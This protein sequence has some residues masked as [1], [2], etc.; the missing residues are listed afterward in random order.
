MCGQHHTNP[1]C[2]LKLLT[3]PGGP[4]LLNTGGCAVPASL[5]PSQPCAAADQ[6]VCD[7]HLQAIN[8][9]HD[10]TAL[11]SGVLLAVSPQHVCSQLRDLCLAAWRG[12]AAR[13]QTG[14]QKSGN[15]YNWNVESQ[16]Q[17]TTY[18]C[19]CDGGKQMPGADSFRAHAGAHRLHGAVFYVHMLMGFAL[20]LSAYS[21][22]QLED[23]L[24][25]GHP[26]VGRWCLRCL[27]ARTPCRANLHI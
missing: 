15:K 7:G 16:A 4:Q 24:L 2:E 22:I 23:I 20:W 1:L 13:Q 9:L 19:Q 11:S 10:S 3:P 18:A 6:P 17:R 14:P 26:S 5:A 12:S 25:C 21:C 8:W 27:Q